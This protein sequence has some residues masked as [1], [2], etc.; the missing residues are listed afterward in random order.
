[1]GKSVMMTFLAIIIGHSFVGAW[2]MEK[3]SDP[4]PFTI[5]PMMQPAQIKIENAR[6]I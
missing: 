1:M 5:P 6:F 2:K 4:A 3:I